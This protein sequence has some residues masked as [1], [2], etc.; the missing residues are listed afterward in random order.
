MSA[1]HASRI[2]LLPVDRRRAATTRIFS[3]RGDTRSRAIGVAVQS[4]F[5]PHTGAGPDGVRRVERPMAMGRFWPCYFAWSR[6]YA[7]GTI[8]APRPLHSDLVRSR[9]LG[10]C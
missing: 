8:R 5:P 6:L 4:A 9:R 1:S 3:C 10:F 7:L 2:N